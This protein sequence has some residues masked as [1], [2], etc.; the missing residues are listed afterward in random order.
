MPLKKNFHDLSERRRRQIVA[1]KTQM[2]L[3]D[4]DLVTS[5]DEYL[6]ENNEANELNNQVEIGINIGLEQNE[7]ILNVDLR[8][9]L[10]QCNK[11]Q[12]LAN[13]K[14]DN[15]EE[16]RD[17]VIN[18][19]SD[20]ENFD[21]DLIEIDSENEDL[22][23]ENDLAEWVCTRKNITVD[24]VNALLKI[25]RKVKPRLPKDAGTLKDTPK[26]TTLYNCEAGE[27]FHYGLEECLHDVLPKNHKKNYV[28]IMFNIDGLPVHNSTQ[29]ALW[30]I[31][32]KLIIPNIKKPFLIGGYFGLGKPN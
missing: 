28:Q 4:V 8:P 3:M 13:D 6:L 16:L 22:I 23:F 1:E 32:G 9:P 26:S 12:A 5:E 10:P 17:D 15:L 29:L 31:Q 7:N 24:D 18:G 27:Y 21:Y 20:L 11:N 2:D 30:P 19:N 25:L 14:N